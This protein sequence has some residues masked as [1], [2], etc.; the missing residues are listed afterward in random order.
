M[1][2]CTEHGYE[3]LDVETETKEPEKLVVPL[4]VARSRKK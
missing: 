2:G 4:Q 1:C 3:K